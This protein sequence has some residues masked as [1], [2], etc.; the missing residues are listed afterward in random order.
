MYARE[1]KAK[2]DLQKGRSEIARLKVL[3]GEVSELMI[4]SLW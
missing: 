2:V 1:F 4:L 3:A